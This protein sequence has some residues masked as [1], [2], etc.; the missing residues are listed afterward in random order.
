V[1][2]SGCVCGAGDAPGL[3]RIKAV[4]A[5]AGIAQLMALTAAR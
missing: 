3:L 1:L 4:E 5:A 2:H